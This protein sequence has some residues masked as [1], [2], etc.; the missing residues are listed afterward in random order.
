MR[1]LFYW[2]Q[3]PGA[4]IVNELSEN[5][6]VRR[7]L[8]ITMLK[9][10]LHRAL[11]SL[12]M[13]GALSSVPALAQTC[14]SSIPKGDLVAEGKISFSTNPTLRPLQYIDAKGALQGMNIELGDEIAK[15][16]CL[17]VE[18]I[19]MDFPAMYA[20]LKAGRFD[21]V[22]TG[23]FW[24]EERSKIMFTV[25]YALS[26]IDIV[27]APDRKYKFTSADELEGLAI[28]VEADSYQERWLREREKD[29]V[30]KG[31]KS[32]RILS[33]ATAS[34][35]MAALRA[36]QMDLAALP[37]YAAAEF[38]R[39]GQ[40][41]MVLAGQGGTPT[42]M[43]FRSKSVAEAVAKALTDMRNDGTYDKILDEY[44]MTKLPEKR[45]TIRGTGP[46]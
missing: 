29:N 35:V 46:V 28:A 44:G 31:R 42:M 10:L 30:A 15:R 33:F 43:S 12:A 23:N 3:V 21:G 38:V 25:P 27:M 45:I 4:F 19:R 6:L 9:S 2:R 20:A 22:N 41:T 34:E 39:R 14:S 11:L 32:I 7:Y 8:E 18:Y 26:A 16:L 1:R 13:L 40:A 5:F 24:T 17:Q 36:G 37:N